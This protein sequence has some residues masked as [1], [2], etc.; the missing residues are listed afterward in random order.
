LII[1]ISPRHAAIQY[2]FTPRLSRHSLRLFT[3]AM[4][5]PP[6]R[7]DAAAASF[8]TASRLAAYAADAAR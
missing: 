6:M 1:E 2:E 3:R 5:T 7:C 8:D 4:P